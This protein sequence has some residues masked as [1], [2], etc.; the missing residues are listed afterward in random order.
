MEPHVPE[1]LLT[2][3]AATR[4]VLLV[5]VLSLIWFGAARLPLPRRERLM[6]AGILTAGLL[7]WFTIARYLGQQNVYWAPDNPTFPTI[8]F[9]IL[10]PLLLGLVLIARSARMA[11]FVD[12]LPL[13]WLVG[14]QAYRV[15]GAVFLV[16]WID[17][18][19][20]WQF[21]IPAG[22]G[23][24]AT[25]LLAV[26]VAAMVA[27]EAVGAHR[28]AYAWCLFGIA[29]LVI[30]VGM[31]ALTSPG[32]MHFLALDEP[33]MLVT[34]YPLVMIP[35]F[36]VPVSIILHGICLWKLRRLR[37]ET[38]AGGVAAAAN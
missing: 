13:S 26:I 18:H 8:Q 19:L 9:G 11:R 32:R 20:P 14:I 23:D 24:V 29:D 38:C 16:L 36:A 17:G 22:A 27:R 15:L 5:A 35:T 2:F 30:A 37:T 3:N 21:A 34:A 28:A 10:V 25:G 6:T 33:N 4:V 1:F 12:A 31:G 7:G